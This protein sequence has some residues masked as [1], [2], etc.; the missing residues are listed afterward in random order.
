MSNSQ[1]RRSIFSGLLL[2]FL[3][4]LFLIFRFDPS[5]HLGTLI[6]R[7]WPVLIILWGLAKLFDHLAAR[8]SGERT[9]VL[10]GGEAALLI[11]VIFCLAGL[12]VADRIRK[13]HP[14]FDFRFDPFAE[15]YT[16][17]DELPA[18]KVA[19][20]SHITIETPR[21][22]ISVHV[23]DGSDLRVTVNKSAADSSESAADRRMDATKAVI[24][25]TSDGF[26]VHPTGVGD[27]GGAVT[28]NLDVEVPKGAQVTATTEHG[29]ISV[30][31][32]GGAVD[33]GT[34]DGDVDIHDTASD[35]NARMA[36]GDLRV[37]NVAGSVR[38]NGRGNG[39]DVSDVGGDATLDGEFFGPIRVRNVAKTTH[40]VS[41][42]SDL[43]L[44]KMTGRMEMDSGDL[45]ISDV[46]GGVKLLTH[47]KDMDVE[48][49][50]GPLEIV[51]SH[52]DI[53][54]R[55]AQPPTN[56][57]NVTNDS[58]EVSLTLPGESGFEI[59]AMT[60][61]GDVS[62]EFEGSGLQQTNDENVGKLAGKYGSHGP[63]ITIATSY[64]TISLHK[65]S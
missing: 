24:E 44:V 15:K 37:A 57:V 28:V 2:I 60:K 40:F 41:Q 20:G 58:G 34:S 13:R 45:E 62:T 48:N 47:N 27:E 11:L 53:K 63:K 54:I 30:A 50:A 49:V 7:F 55:F 4:T 23:G 59:S 39:I 21:G 31:G 17:S 10:S 33:V 46:A 65:R 56:A 35:V 32:L 16:R 51:D 42:R 5:L 1:Q 22:S 25:A 14:N 43:T 6:W 36:K 8:R 9:T 61:G 52:G 19:A 12:G 29:D 64:G 38:V 3:G 18:Q 26:S